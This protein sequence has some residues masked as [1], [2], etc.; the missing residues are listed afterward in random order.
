MMLTLN[1]ALSP[2]FGVVLKDPKSPPQKGEKHF[3][4]GNVNYNTYDYTGHT[5]HKAEL[6]K[7]EKTFLKALFAWNKNNKDP[8]LTAAKNKAQQEL[9]AHLAFLAKEAE[10]ASPQKASLISKA[11]IERAERTRKKQE[12][13]MLRSLPSI[14][15]HLKRLE[16]NIE[17]QKDPAICI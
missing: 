10:A 15:P 3:K 17:Q 9:N 1:T 13:H 4:V 5:E 7:R 14:E 16:Q 8:K 11:D 2:K 6:V 12:N